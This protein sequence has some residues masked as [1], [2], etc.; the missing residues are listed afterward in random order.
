MAGAILS[1]P[2]TVII[3]LIKNKKSIQNQELATKYNKI[4]IQEAPSIHLKK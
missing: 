1:A 4:R 3:L 2:V